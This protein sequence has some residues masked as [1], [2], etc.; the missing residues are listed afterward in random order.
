MLP[1]ALLQPATC[2]FRVATVLYQRSL[3][4]ELGFV[5]HVV[6]DDV[7]RPA[8]PSLSRSGNLAANSR[9]ALVLEDAPAARLP[10][11]LLVASYLATV[12][13]GGATSSRNSG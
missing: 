4:E 13:G 11:I 12:L 9:S 5:I 8:A 1:V 3:P 10:F 2:L 6:T 7:G